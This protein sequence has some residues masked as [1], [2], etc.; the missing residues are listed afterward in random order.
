MTWEIADRKNPDR[1]GPR[2]YE[3]A[4]AARVC[5]LASP[6]GRFYLRWVGRETDRPKMDGQRAKD[7]QDG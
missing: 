2:Y 6:E 4:R 7:G 1:A 5:G 3:L